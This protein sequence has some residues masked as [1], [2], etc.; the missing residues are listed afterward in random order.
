MPDTVE[1]IQLFDYVQMYD[2]GTR[3]VPGRRCRSS[4]ELFRSAV[5]E[6]VNVYDEQQ[7]AARPHELHDLG[8]SS[9]IV[10]VLHGIKELGKQR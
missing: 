3:P 9:R 6:P 5:A 7:N 10:F 4:A 8:Q 1:I 2:V